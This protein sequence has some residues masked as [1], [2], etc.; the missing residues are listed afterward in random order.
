MVNFFPLFRE[1]LINKYVKLLPYSFN[2]L[3]EILTRTRHRQKISH[4]DEIDDFLLLYGSGSRSPAVCKLKVKEIKSRVVVIV[5]VGI[6]NMSLGH[7]LPS[8]LH[9][10]NLILTLA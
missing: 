6:V 5:H 3:S 7:K 9:A 10:I 2:W 8:F 1:R 4:C